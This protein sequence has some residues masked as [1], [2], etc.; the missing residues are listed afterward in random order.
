[1]VGEGADEGG[2]EG[3]DH[4]GEEDETSAGRAPVEDR[5]H[6]EGEDG[7]KGGA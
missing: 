1:M 2:G 4:E 3:R 6:A 5:L 7:V